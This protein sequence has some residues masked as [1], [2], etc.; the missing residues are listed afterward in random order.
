[1]QCLLINAEE[2]DAGGASRLIDRIL[3]FR[4]RAI[5]VM[6]GSPSSDVVRECLARGVRV[7]LVN[8][9]IEGAK[10]DTIL[11]DDLAGARLAV[12]RLVDAG[13]RRPAIVA[14]G[15]G[16]LSITRRLDAATAAFR[17][18]GLKPVV[19]AQGA[20][21]YETGAEAALEILGDRRIDGAFCVTD[22]IALGFIDAARTQMRRKIPDEISVIGF[23]DIPQAA[24]R[25]Y[26]MTTVRQPVDALTAAIVQAI[27][28]N[29]NLTQP[30]S[31]RLPVELVERDT[32]RKR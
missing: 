5:V 8:K 30:V 31:V 19:W 7:I 12:R 10:A 16:T 15:A 25:N 27:V 1:M 17:R 22:L 28:R 6:S 9:R 13:C 2:A 11:S 24:W 20:T 29:P 14:S 3:E 23:D 26:R 4:V 18:V 32:V 21:S